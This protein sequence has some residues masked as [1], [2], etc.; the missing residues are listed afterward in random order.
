MWSMIR[1][2]Y[3]VFHDNETEGDKMP[4]GIFTVRVSPE[5]QA[6]LDRLA[7]LLDRSRTYLVSQA[8][9]D[10]LDVHRWQIEQTKL[11]ISEADA[12]DFA[13]DDEIELLNAR[14]RP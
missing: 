9:D 2:D 10:Y 7:T 6:Q 4:Q 5:K 14:F 8:I 1:N 11:A 12:G 13:T 3:N